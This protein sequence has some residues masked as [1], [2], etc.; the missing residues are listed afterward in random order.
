[1][2]DSLDTNGVSVHW[3]GPHIFHTDDENVFQ[4]LQR[5]SKWYPY[6][7]R[8]LGRIDGKLVPIP[9][10]FCSIDM[11][12]S[13]ND[14]EQI[15]AIL[16]MNFPSQEKASILELMNHDNHT[17][18]KF[19]QFVFEKVFLNYT[20]KQWGTSPEN[21]DKSVINRVPVVIG[22]DD[23][24]FQD[25]TQF[26]PKEGY[27]QIFEN[28]LNHKNL[29]VRL[30]C[31]ASDVINLDIEEHKIYFNG[32][33]FSGPVIFTGA[34]DEL[35]NYAY[36]PLPYRTLELV[37]E[38]KNCTQF[39]SA[40][41]VNYPNEEEFTRITE[42]KHLTMQK[43]ENTTTILK[44]Y[45]LPYDPKAE[46]GN[47]PYYVIENPDNR[48]LYNRYVNLAKLFP[49]LYLCGRLA[50]YKYYNMDGAIKNALQL[51]KSIF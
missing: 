32:E 44:E 24:Y 19:G 26:M 18:K 28:M 48:M 30:N 29:T 39:Q 46:K 10:N 12:Y 22:Y 50:E 49:N 20:A 43:I 34:I 3:Y 4:Y 33:T 45:P 1:M 21:V 11:L 14:A 42:F 17:I 7:H 35:F 8:V 38:Q 9:F 37:F 2:Y 23:R 47:I 6:E 31:N 25:K 13:K 41:V 40:A 36:G 16:K 15:K 51:V 5:F 27:T